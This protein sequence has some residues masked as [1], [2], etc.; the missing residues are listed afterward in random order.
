MTDSAFLRGL[1][2]WFG[3]F[4][5]LAALV[6]GVVAFGFL[7]VGQSPPSMDSLHLHN[8]DGANHSVRLELVAANESTAALS[9]RLDLG[10]DE[11]RSFDA[12]TER[13]RAYRLVVTV[14]DSDRRSFDVEGPDDLCTIEVRIDANAT[15]ETGTSC[16]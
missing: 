4:A 16:A 13:G 5:V 11:R 6:G 3:G 2:L 12:A 9:A 8:A 15:V 7:G 1:L 10:P 14:D